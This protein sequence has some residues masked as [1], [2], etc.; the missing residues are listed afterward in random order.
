VGLNEEDFVK[1]RCW[2]LDLDF[3]V[4]DSPSPKYPVVSHREEEIL[5]PSGLHG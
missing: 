2:I 1:Q 4:I 3:A 5:S